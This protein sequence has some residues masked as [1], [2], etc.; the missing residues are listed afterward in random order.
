LKNELRDHEREDCLVDA[1]SGGNVI[2]AS[3]GIQIF[4]SPEFSPESSCRQ[5]VLHNLYGHQRAEDY[6][7][8]S[9]IQILF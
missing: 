6:L 5:A 1:N 4:I 7:L 3:P 8:M 2:C 9:G